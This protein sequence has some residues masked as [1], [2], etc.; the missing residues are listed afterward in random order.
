[1]SLNYSASFSGSN[2]LSIANYTGNPAAFSVSC[3]VYLNTSQVSRIFFSDFNGSNNWAPGISDGSTNQIKFF[4]GS[5]TVTSPTVLVN[6]TWYH[7]IFTH[8]GTTAKIYLNGNTTPNASSV[9][10]ITYGAVATNNYIGS[11]NGSSQRLNGR[12]AG[13]GYWS[14]A[15]STTEVTSLWNNGQGLTGVELSGSLLT[16][17]G[18][19]HDFTNSASLG[20][21]SSGNSHTYTNNG[22]VVQAFGPV[23]PYVTPITRSQRPFQP[24]VQSRWRSGLARAQVFPYYQMSSFPDPASYASYTTAGTVAWGRN[25]YGPCMAPNDSTGQ[26]CLTMGTPIASGATTFTLVSLALLDTVIA[27]NVNRELWNAAGATVDLRVT[28]NAGLLQFQVGAD[29]AFT[30]LTFDLPILNVPVVITTRLAAGGVRSLWYNAFKVAERT[31]ASCVYGSA[32]GALNL[33]SPSVLTTRNWSGQINGGHVWTRALQDEEIIALASDF[34][35][36]VRPSRQAVYALAAIAN[37]TFGIP[38]ALLPAM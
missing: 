18:S 7:A 25:Q 38:A 24:V 22:T 2:D 14:K 8:D 6:N 28:L 33:G 10:A 20:T 13:V 16:S 17:L 34:F 37:E 35:A 11:L 15:L 1:M 19:Y 26:G 21:D 31:D 23:P 29:A 30:N 3:W 5:A 12:L 9:S 36:P 32:G 27:A 4:L